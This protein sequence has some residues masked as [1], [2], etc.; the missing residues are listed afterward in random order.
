MSNLCAHYATMARNNRW[1]NYRLHAVCGALP[2]EEYH[3]RRES[4]FGSIHATLEHILIVDYAYY[5]RLTGESHSAED[6]DRVALTEAQRVSDERLI[7]YC[8]RLRPT[9]LERVVT[10]VN[11]EGVHNADP[12]H[13]VLS[14]LF[15]HQIHHRGQVHGLL[16]TTSVAPPQL[17]EFF[18]SGDLPRRER[19]LAEIGLH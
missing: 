14:H 2:D 17:D 13:H 18:L 15:V 16:S 8:D 6:L 9:S 1:S 3:R 19:E 12:V 7:A 11:S 10:F 5:N 4:F